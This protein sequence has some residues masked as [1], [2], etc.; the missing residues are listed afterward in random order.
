MRPDA[1]RDKVAIIGMG[2]TK[3]GENWDKSA[4][5]MIVD[6]TFEALQDAGVE[7][8]DIEA[9]W[10]GTFWSGVTGSAISQPLKL[11]NLP[12]AR[13]ENG[14]ATG[15]EAFRTA[16][17]GVASGLYDLV[18]VVGFEKLKDSGLGGLPD[19]IFDPVYGVGT[20]APGMWAL[21]ATRYFEV[22]RLS[23]EEG[24]RMLA[25]VSVKNHRN[26]SL[27]PK[28]HYQKA[29]T[30]EQAVKAPIVAYP[31]G[32]FDCCAVTDG[33]AA[34]VLCSAEIAK[35]FR[36]DYILVKGFG[37]AIGPAL[38]KEDVDYELGNLPETALAGKM[39]YEAAGITN[40]QEQVA[41]AQVHD[42]FTIAEVLECEALQF[43]PRGKY[44]EHVEAGFFDL[45]GKI[46]VNSDGGLKAFGHPVGATG[47]RMT[48]EIY[49]Q[50]QGKAE[51]P[52][53]QVKGDLRFGLVMPQG[54]LPGWLM[55]L[56]TILG[57]RG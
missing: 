31:L 39:A 22:N 35:K 40:P 30:L 23:P 47:V 6:A 13:S 9:G 38:G 17:F 32:L 33:A 25:R 5:D 53:R 4:N 3:F 55:P 34:A 15:S 52:E 19:F 21:A 28:A 49:K 20:T 57:K 41:V 2:C 12:L 14:C 51:R 8:K 1:I 27:H 45:E 11:R 16:C 10:V 37:L 18:L 42:C 36:D 44:K 7:L 43:C 48:Y 24:R 29:I 56:V 26:G 46:P 54:G 50:L